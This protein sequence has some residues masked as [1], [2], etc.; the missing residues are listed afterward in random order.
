MTVAGAASPRRDVVRKAKAFGF[1]GLCV[2]AT[3]IGIAALAVLLID[4]AREG[5]GRVSW[6]FINSFPSRKPEIAGIKAA[7]WDQGRAL[8]DDLDDRLHG[9]LRHPRR[10]WGCGV[11]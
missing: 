6:D 7:L 1:A 8:G 4:V 10:C 11:P 5:A 9:G 3:A 2:L